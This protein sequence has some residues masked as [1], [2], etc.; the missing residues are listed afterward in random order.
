MS[1]VRS[2][3]DVL[4]ERHAEQLRGSRIGLAAH[5]ASVDASLVHAS[6]R[7]GSVRGAELVRLFGPEHGLDGTAQDMIS[8]R[9]RD[10]GAS[11]PIISLYGDSEE[12]L[13]PPPGSLDGLDVLVIDFMDVGSRYY[14]YGATMIHLM[15][16]AAREGLR[17]VVCDRPNPIGGVAIEGCGIDEGYESFV[18][19]RPIPQRH[20]LSLGELARYVVRH[21]G[22]DVELEVVP[23]LGWSRGAWWDQ[24]GL[25]W[26][27][28]S[29]NMPTL[30]TATVYPGA[31]LVEGTTLSEGRGTTRPFE[32]VGAPG[33]DGRALVRELE[34]QLAPFGESGVRARPCVFR[35]AFQKHAGVDCGGLQIHVRDR[36][37]L[38]PLRLGL[39]LLVAAHRVAPQTFGWRTEPYEFVSD[40]PAID[41]LVG[42]RRFREAVE[43]GADL[44]EIDALFAVPEAY[45]ERRREVLIYP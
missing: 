6:A 7:L 41:L 21:G 29:P 4:C 16:A 45:L 25:P 39:G 28:P 12:S 1:V 26:V 31:C 32:L 13:H 2:G 22:L 9:D 23:A 42:H 30:D 10:A 34:A 20:G 3:L 24:T 14:T 36:E 33:I 27:M 8:V 5:A 11:P 43:Q 38:R 19:V 44:A 40:P 17:V 37:T 35:P 18:G 15:E